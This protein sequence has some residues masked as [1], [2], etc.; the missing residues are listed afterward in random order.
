MYH[1]TKKGIIGVQND[2][3]SFVPDEV[4]SAQVSYRG[5]I[6]K[7]FNSPLKYIQSAGALHDL[8]QVSLDAIH[9]T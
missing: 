7:V 5:I 8:G 4:F 6:P 3:K 9:N 1:F 2:K